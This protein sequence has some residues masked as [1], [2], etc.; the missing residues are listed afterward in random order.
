MGSLITIGNVNTAMAYPAKSKAV[1][2]V[3]TNRKASTRYICSTLTDEGFSFF[4]M[5]IYLCPIPIT[6]DGVDDKNRKDCLLKI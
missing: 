6:L 1:P 3:L 2:P 4:A 5:T